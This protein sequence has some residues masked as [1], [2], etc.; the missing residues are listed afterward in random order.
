MPPNTLRVHTY[1]VLVKSVGPKVLWAVA[2]KTS[3]AGNWGIFPFPPVPCL[4]WGGEDR[5]CRHL[6]SLREFHR[7]KSY[8]YPVW[9]SRLRPMTGATMDFGSLVLTL[10][11]RTRGH[12]TTHLR[13]KEDIE[14]VSSELDN[15]VKGCTS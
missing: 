6:S 10:S 13:V 12:G 4:N 14:D 11:D 3:S 15:K 5:W 2:A 8:C 7:A 9:R 1:Y